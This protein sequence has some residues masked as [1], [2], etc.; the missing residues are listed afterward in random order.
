M[1]PIILRK[2]RTLAKRERITVGAMI[3]NSLAEF[4][5]TKGKK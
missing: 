4:M 3:R 5:R 1:D 2:I